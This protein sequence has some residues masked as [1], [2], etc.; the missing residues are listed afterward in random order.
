MLWIK[1]LLYFSNTEAFKHQYF[2]KAVCLEANL[3]ADSKITSF[4]MFLAIYSHKPKFGA[5]AQI[6]SSK[7][8]C[9]LALCCTSSKICHPRLKFTL[10]LSSMIKWEEGLWAKLFEAV[11]CNSIALRLAKNSGTVL[12]PVHITQL[13]EFF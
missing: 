13:W 9:E 2:N 12:A 1:I 6:M 8:T 7:S 3:S 4:Q 10:F 11:L 5:T